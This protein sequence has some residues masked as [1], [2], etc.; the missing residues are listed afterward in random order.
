[1]ISAQAARRGSKGKKNSA[2]L[3]APRESVVR[4]FL[5]RRIARKEL[6]EM[7]RDRRLRWAAVIIFSLLLVSLALGWQHYREVSR[8][9]EEA[10]RI[11]REQW[12]NQGEKNPHSAAHYG[13]YAFKP[14]M[15]LSLL[16][17]GI[18][19]YTGVAVWLEA[20]K[21][22]DF[23]YR[24]A[25]DATAVQR[26]GELTGASVL[27]FFLPLLIVLLTFTTFAGEREQGTMR[28]ILSLGVSPK[29]LAAG[30][31]L[32]AA[33][34]VGVLLV[35][36]AVLGVIAIGLASGDPMQMT[37]PRL[38]VM[39]IGYLLYFGAFIGISLAVSA[40]ASSSRQA[41]VVLLAFWIW[42]SLVS[43]RAATD[44]ARHL[45]PTP[46]AFEFATRVESEIR[47]GI[48]GHNPQDRRLET[49]KS[50][51]LLKY[52]VSR[53]ED[54]PINFTGVAMQASEEYGGEVFD[55]NYGLLWDQYERQNRFQVRA[56]VVAPILAIRSLS[57]GLAG[58]DFSQHRSFASAAEEYR[59]AM[60][61]KM[62]RD[63]THNAQYGQTFYIADRS[64]WERLEPFE[65]TAPEFQDV[66]R[67][68]VWTLA[69][70][71]AWFAAGI[72]AAAASAARLRAD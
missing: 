10:Q 64:L 13:V 52:G 68:Q 4:Q 29:T 23:K 39:S 8:Q 1:M 14:K 33:C 66:L 69:A 45:Y 7:L 44:I 43:P 72:A 36:A 9:H 12:L 41:L 38:L 26:F 20:H 65:Y 25:Q 40:A 54:L 37:F 47:N 3:A 56:A 62:N 21:Q 42:N 48:D 61:R 34:A 70:L 28:Q 27:Q 55:R 31:A 53:L 19:G 17:K 16:D 51:L 24:P 50:E 49:L 71:L 58:T 5:V 6:V 59:R 46:S 60:I 22:N 32:G 63:V 11:T 18:D 30:K 35:P 15:P 67:N 2:D 57:M